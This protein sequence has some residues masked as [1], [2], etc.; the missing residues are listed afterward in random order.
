[1]DGPFVVQIITGFSAEDEC[2]FDSEQI[3]QFIRLVNLR[4]CRAII[5]VFRGILRV[6]APK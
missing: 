1:M 2:S 4:Y 3:L 5:D 6:Q